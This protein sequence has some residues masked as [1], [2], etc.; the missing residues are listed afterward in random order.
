LFGFGKKKYDNDPFCSYPFENVEIRPTGEVYFCCQGWIRENSIG[1]IY[2]TPF[3]EIWNSDTARAIRRSILNGDYKF[4]DRKICGFCPAR[5]PEVHI[6]GAVDGHYALPP[7]TVFFAPSYECNLS[8]V[9]CRKDRIFTSDARLNKLKS[10]ID[11]VFL[12]IFSGVESVGFSGSGDPFADRF[13]RELVGRTAASYPNIRF[14][15]HTNGVLASPEML[16]SLGVLNR[17]NNIQVSLHSATSE[18]WKKFTRGSDDQYSALMDNLKFISDLRRDGRLPYFVLSFVVASFNYH[19]LI[20]FVRLAQSLGA[21][22]I[23]VWGYRN[24]GSVY[25]GVADEVEGANIQTDAEAS[26]FSVHT[27]PHAEYGKLGEILR[28]P[29]FSDPKIELYPEIKKIRDEALQEA[30]V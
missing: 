19:E 1:N 17:M 22:K 8:C 15:F 18:T 5:H 10:Q 3:H 16:Q 28:H 24:G 20:D 7:K 9:V 29:V 27:P 14:F 26:A 30:G 23:S 21:D 4:C 25:D 2:K 11:S 13:C 12:P 6:L